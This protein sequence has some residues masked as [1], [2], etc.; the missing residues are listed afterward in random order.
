MAVNPYAVGDED[1]VMDL[2]AAGGPRGREPEGEGALAVWL[3]MEQQRQL[4][5]GN[6]SAAGM[7]ALRKN[8]EGMPYIGF[9][10]RKSSLC[11]GCR[12]FRVVE[13]SPGEI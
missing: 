5:Q 3:I 12:A 2:D 1:D 4:N 7:A 6:V 10:N 8:R 9:F 13:P 11:D